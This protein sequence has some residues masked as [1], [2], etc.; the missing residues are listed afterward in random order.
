[1]GG[2]LIP[3]IDKRGQVVWVNR[4]PPACPNGHQ[5]LPGDDAATYAEGWFGCWCDGAQDSDGRP[6]H[7][8]FTCKRCGAVTLV[9]ECTD[10]AQKNGWAGNH[11]Q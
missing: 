1:M 11:G 10:P 9:P 3:I 6:G 5:L 7:V 8:T 4:P 2:D